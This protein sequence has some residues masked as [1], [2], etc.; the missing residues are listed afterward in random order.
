MNRLLADMYQ[1]RV[2]SHWRIAFSMPSDSAERAA[3]C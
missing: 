1:R 3:R 2:R